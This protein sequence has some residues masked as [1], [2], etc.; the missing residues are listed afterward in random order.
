MYSGVAVYEMEVNKVSVMRRR[1]DS[2]LNATQILKVA[3]VDK[4]K[5]TKVLEKEILA[6]EH[7]KVQGGYGKYQGTWITY[8]RG[9]DLCRQYG[10]EEALRPLLEYDM[11]QDGISVAGRGSITTPTKE[12]ALA[13]QR[14]KLMYNGHPENRQPAQ[15]PSGTFFKNISATAANAVNAINKARLDSPVSR[16]GSSKKKPVQTRRPSQPL[17]SSLPGSSQHSSQTLHSEASLGNV[18]R[19]EPA[20]EATYT[21]PRF[22]NHQSSGSN[23]DMHAPAAKRARPSSRGVNMSMKVRKTTASNNNDFLAYQPAAFPTTMVDGAFGGL[24]P[25]PQP[26]T[27]V[28][29]EKQRLLIELF[30]DP[31]QTDFSNHPAF[32]RLAGEDLDIPMDVT[33]HTAL[34]WAATLARISLLRAL[35]FKGASIYRVNVGGETALIRAAFT[36]NNLDNGSFPYLLELLGPTIE[37]RDGRGRTL[38]HHI[39]VSSAVHKKGPAC[40]YYLESLLEF[41]VRQGS[42]PSSQVNSFNGDLGLAPPRPRAIGLARF[43][44]DMVN[45]TD[46]AGDTALNLVARIGNKSI[47]QQLLEVGASP[48]IPNH[49][50]LKPVDFGVG[51]DPDPADASLSSQQSI[52]NSEKTMVNR[53]A[54]SS[55]DLMSCKYQ[56]FQLTSLTMNTWRAVPLCIEPP[57]FP[58]EIASTNPLFRSD[59]CPCINS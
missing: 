39:A 9:R 18:P 16:P 52:P 25:L 23:L 43:M 45:A 54:E 46:R 2:W 35:I 6:D 56:P 42:A 24:P 8:K 1:A 3:G 21:P 19:L 4:G 14:K 13:A 44:T 41:V 57:S 50:G 58:V 32:E 48:I 20:F 11:G 28:D 38:L 27:P 51:G 49:G 55:R 34:H 15:S 53:V 10:V 47:I 36:T 12:Q 40:K 59:D 37:M 33:A 5:R 17:E 26:T 31:L 29:Q 22:T 30:M 7:E